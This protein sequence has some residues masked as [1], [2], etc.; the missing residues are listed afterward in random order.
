MIGI[1][2]SLRIDYGTRLHVRIAI[3]FAINISIRIQ[4]NIAITNSLRAVIIIEFGL[5]LD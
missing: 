3:N 5:D 4:T 2:F 1:E